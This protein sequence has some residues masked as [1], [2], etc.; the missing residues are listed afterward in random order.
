MHLQPCCGAFDLKGFEQLKDLNNLMKQVPTDLKALDQVLL[1]FDQHYQPSIPKKVWLQCQ[2]ALAEGFTNAVRHAHKG[3][4]TDVPIEIEVT[5]YPQRIEMRIWD[6]GA[7]FDLEQRIQNLD[8]KLDNLAG[9]GRGIAILQKIADQLSYA[10]T[11][12]NRNCLLV[13]KHYQELEN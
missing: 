12:D 11:E 6:H 7:P 4:S 8:Q 5:L 1:W 3:L 2:L 13:V 10:R 9:G